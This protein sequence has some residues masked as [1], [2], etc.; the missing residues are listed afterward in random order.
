MT[1]KERDALIQKIFSL[2]RKN[3]TFFL[4]GHQ[5]PDGDTVASELAM[6]S[7]LS[8]L[9]KSVEIYNQEAVPA[10]LFFLPGVK[11]IKAAKKV[12]KNYD[13]AIIFECYDANR[14]GNIIDLKKQARAVINIDHHLKHSFFGDINFINPMASSNAEQLYYFFE[15]MGL[16]ITQEEASCLYVGIM[17]DTG[18]FQYSNTNAETLRIASSLLQQGVEVH[19]LCEKIY[20]THSFSALKLLGLS[21]SRMQ[22]SCDGKI[23]SIKITQEDFDKTNSTDDETEEIVNYG[24]HV[25]G[26]L[27]SILFRESV[28][29]D[30]S[31]SPPVR[32]GMI[33]VSLRSRRNVN[34]CRLAE[35]FGGGGHKYA[36]GCKVSG[37][38]EKVSRAILSA[39]QKLLR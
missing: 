16:P 7:L 38:I 12:D 17:M 15:K 19:T 3:K 25:P 35:Q 26:A 20:G 31:A 23:A 8:R 9:H 37:R 6:A 5:K 39:A 36:A 22:M 18:R 29:K 2:I 1:L 33:K 30:E 21:L 10:S 27:I 11:K 28:L 34:V 32:N 4:S 24:L 14:M 13:V